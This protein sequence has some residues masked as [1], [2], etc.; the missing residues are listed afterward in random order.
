MTHLLM[1]TSDDEKNCSSEARFSGG[2]TMKEC[3]MIS[4]CTQY[5]GASSYVNMEQQLQLAHGDKG[6]L[7]PNI[8]CQY[9]KDTAHTKDSCVQLNNKIAH[10]LQLQKQVTAAKTTS[11]K[12]PG[13]TFSKNNSSSDLGPV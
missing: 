8:T 9:C 5:K 10:E 6:K 7:E 2:M 3:P 1:S 12:V 13:L 11:K 4:Q